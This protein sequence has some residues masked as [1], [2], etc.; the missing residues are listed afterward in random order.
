MKIGGE[1]F[2][3]KRL[4]LFYRKNDEN[5]GKKSFLAIPNQSYILARLTRVIKGGLVWYQY[6]GLKC[7]LNS[8]VLEIEFLSNHSSKIEI[9]EKK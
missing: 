4:F 6:D 5:G 8:F 3:F 2:L 1:N 7:A 9:N